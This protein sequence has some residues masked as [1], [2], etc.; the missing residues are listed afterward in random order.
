M[1]DLIGRMLGPYQILSEIGHGGM[2]NVYRASQP[3]VGREVAVKVLPVY[4]LQQRSFLERFNLEIKIIARLQ[5][6]RI[7]PV[8]DSGEADGMPYIVMAYI[9][10]GTL[11][12]RIKSA[13]NKMPLEEVMRLAAQIAD[14]LDHAHEQGVIHL[15]FKPSNVLLDRK[16]NVY[17]ADFG[18]ARVVAD[19]GPSTGSG[20]FGTPHY[21]APEL[22]LGGKI[23]PQADVYSF[24]A[25]LF[26]M[27]TGRH[28]Y[29]GDTPISIIL[30]HTTRPVP[31]AREHR[32]RLPSAVQQVI[33]WAMAK[34]PADRPDSAGALVKLL[35]RAMSI[36]GPDTA[37]ISPPT[38]SPTLISTE[39]TPLPVG[40]EDDEESPDTVG[41]AE[42]T[43]PSDSTKPEKQPFEPA[44]VTK[45]MMPLALAVLGGG[46]VLAALTIV[47]LVAFNSFGRTISPSTQSA[48]PSAP[49]TP[50]DIV[51]VR[52]NA[53]WKPVIHAFN[54]IDMV[55]VP[56]GCFMMG[57]DSGDNE[58]PA[59][60]QCFDHPFWIDRT[61]VTN[62]QFSK[63][64]GNAA[65]ISRWTEDNRPR[66][67]ISWVEASA[68]CQKHGARL[69][70]EAEWEYAARGP[71]GLT[72]PWGNTFDPDQVVFG[73]NS[74]G[75]TF[76]VGSKPNGASWVGALDMSGNVYEWVSSIFR[77]Y[78]YKA[79]DGRED[80]ND[81]THT[82]VA[83]G[84]SWSIG[85]TTALS[86]S[87]RSGG[88]PLS[89]K[90]DFGFRCALSD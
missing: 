29:D 6:P 89:A 5:H 23:S 44:S 88:D 31:D 77:P 61:E 68:Y 45:R 22:S 37:I 56:S 62:V 90:D 67:N 33:A 42:Q 25:T 65:A 38:A 43:P 64:G 63:L 34:D 20:V 27:V 76:E 14:G 15:D 30:A 11:A 32:P 21:M 24:G 59:N 78:P 13:R 80:A 19:T 55:E 48:T 51:P 28:P 66:E 40:G 10:G 82:R 1:S 7:L 52:Q 2:G 83:R 74:K 39:Q 84:G 49:T 47:A 3:S 81:R 9:Q 26:E 46:T 86:S 8:Y 4:L 75:E 79:D 71:D 85:V 12:D 35:Q 41:L 69:P 72:Y 58:K 18:I 73:K 53:D 54:N 50:T 60:Q 17:L 36:A 70:T 16:D 87:V 57:N